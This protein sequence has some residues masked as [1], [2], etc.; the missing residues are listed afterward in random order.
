MCGFFARSITFIK[1]GYLP[2]VLASH[3]R[4]KEQ[5]EA[6]PFQPDGKSFPLTKKEDG[7]IGKA[8]NSMGRLWFEEKVIINSPEL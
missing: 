4:R 7:H 6:P 8:W 5:V 1:S 3:D 2:H